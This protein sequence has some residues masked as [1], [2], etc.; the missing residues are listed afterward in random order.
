[1]EASPRQSN[2]RQLNFLQIA[3][4]LAFRSNITHR[5]G[6]VVVDPHTDEILSKGFNHTH[7][8]MQHVNSVHAEHDALRKIKKHVDLSGAEIYVVRI[9]PVSRGQAF[10]LSKPCDGCTRL[11][12]RHKVGKVYYSS[13]AQV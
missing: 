9:G 10:T 8:A 11:L 5:H 7:P 13:G 1:M 2:Q 3:G 12:V 4:Q 6:C